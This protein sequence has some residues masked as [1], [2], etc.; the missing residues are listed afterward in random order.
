MTRTDVVTVIS[1]PYGWTHCRGVIGTVQVRPVKSSLKRRCEMRSNAT[2]RKSTHVGKRS[3]TSQ[4]S[5]YQC[6]SRDKRRF[7]FYVHY[8]GKPFCASSER[9]Q[10]SN[11]TF[12][13]DVQINN[14][15][16]KKR[17]ITAKLLKILSSGT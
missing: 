1:F 15:K 14:T 16:K 4:S 8:L 5:S 13:I 7:Y 11:R 2:L 12:S 6:Y 9:S 17:F 3:I 10:T